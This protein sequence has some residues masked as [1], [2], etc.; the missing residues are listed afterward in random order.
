MSRVIKVEF[1]GPD[2]GSGE[3]R[4]ELDGAGADRLKVVGNRTDGATL[5][6]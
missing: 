4:F 1:F 3:E 6:S 5:S 2:P